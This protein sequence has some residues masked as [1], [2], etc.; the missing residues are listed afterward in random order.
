VVKVAVSAMG[1]GLDAEVDPRFGRCA[2]FVIVD[3]DSEEAGPEIIENQ[4]ASA[5]GGAGI[6]TANMM[7]N[8]GVDAVLVNNIGPNAMQ[9]LNAAGIKVYTGV[10]GTVKETLEMFKNGQL[11]LISE[12]NVGPHAGMGMGKGMGKGFGM[13]MGRGRGM[14]GFSGPGGAGQGRGGGGGFGGGRGGG[15]GRG[16]GGGGQ[17]RGW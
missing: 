11:S 10:G 8:K 3:T 7:V 13:G 1:P 2:Y 9:V 16:G 14:G 15:Q 17:G 12:E 5:T 6:Q 4:G